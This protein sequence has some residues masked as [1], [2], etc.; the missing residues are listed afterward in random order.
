MA[1]IFHVLKEEY[2]R[3]LETEKSY[4]KAITNMP[5]GTP[6]IKQRYNKKYLYLQYRNG[7][8]IV[9][10]YI[11]LEGSDKANK[12]LETIAQRK[13]YEKLLRET[14]EALKEVRKALRGKI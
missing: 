2:E 5:K 6:C 11:G 13:R 1:V 8:K 12:I 14:K 4:S 10:D 7:K 3:L 9:Q